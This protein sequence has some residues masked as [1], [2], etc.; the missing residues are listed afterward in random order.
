MDLFLWV[1]R[2][3]NPGVL[4]ALFG[5]SS[6]EGIDLST[7][8]IQV[9]GNDLCRRV[10]NIISALR[11]ERMTYLQVGVGEGKPQWW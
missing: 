2:S 9:E 10:N 11:E 7:L 6:L 3:A 8:Q 5:I 4:S 1:G